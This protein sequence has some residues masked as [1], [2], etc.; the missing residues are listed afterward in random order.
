MASASVVPVLMDLNVLPRIFVQTY[1]SCIEQSC[2]GLLF[3]LAAA[4]GL[5][6]TTADTENSFQQS[7]PLTEQCYLEI[8]DAYRVELDTRTHVIPVMKA[9]QG[10]PEAG[11]LWERMIVGILKDLNFRSTTHERNLYRGEIDG[12]LVLIYRQVDD[13]VVASVTRATASKLIAVINA[14]VTTKDQGLGIRFNGIDL[15]QTRD[16][17]KVS[18][19]TYLDRALLTHGGDKPGIRES[20]RHGPY[21]F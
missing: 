10:H 15:L 8:D 16:C 6:I 12:E 14:R 19:E 2:M 21:T 1:A 4:K 3:A 11:V 9:L 5:L 18:C 7:P 17:I 20:N 13:F